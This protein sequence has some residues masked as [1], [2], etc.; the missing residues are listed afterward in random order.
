MAKPKR[1]PAK[2]A[3]RPAK[4]AAAPKPAVKKA[5]APKP[6]A[7]KAAAPKP[8]V[9]LPRRTRLALTRWAKPGHRGPNMKT[10]AAKLAL[11]KKWIDAQGNV[12]ALGKKVSL[13]N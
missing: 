2:P 13:P 11:A 1:K 8:E 3:A 5:A 9:P 6:A 12:T 4:K 10:P 7:K